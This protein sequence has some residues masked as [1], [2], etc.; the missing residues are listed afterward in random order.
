VVD[1]PEFRTE[2]LDHVA[3]AVRDL[4]R[5]ESFYREV[6]G[7]ERV[8]RE[9]DPPRVMASRGSGL[10]LFPVELHASGGAEGGPPDIRILHIA[11]RVDRP[12]FEAA[13]AALDGHGVQW[14][15]SD[16]DLSH[17]IYFDDPDGHQLELTTYE[18]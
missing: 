5:S 1:E 4:D 14:R 17:S 6:L 15:F 13:Q 10:A 9:W 3:I 11:F 7:L 2:G 16:H 18:V 12:G 8:H